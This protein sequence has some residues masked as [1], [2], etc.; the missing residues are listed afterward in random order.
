MA[1]FT[2]LYD[3]CVLYPNNLRDFL[4]CLAITRLYRARWTDQIHDEWIR[5]VQ[6]DRSDIPRERLERTRKLMAETVLGCLV[7][8]YEDLI[9]CLHLPDP[10]DRHVLAAAIRGRVDVIVT[11]NLKDFPV[12]TLAQYGIDVQHPD[13]FADH[14]LSL[15]QAAV[16]TAAKSHRA[17]LKNPQMTAEE[18]LDMLSKAGLSRTASGLSDCIDLI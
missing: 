1:S 7:T 3:S 8:G 17:R 14:L 6:R 4:M 13:V 12:E 10:D 5:S 9:D 16:C 11:A 2:A 18:Y 15:D